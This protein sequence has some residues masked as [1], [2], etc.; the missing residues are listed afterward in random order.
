MPELLCPRCRQAV[1]AADAAF[2]PFC[3]EK[4]KK[5]GPDLAA[6]LQ[7][8][9]PVKKHDRL[10]ALREQ[11][12]DNLAIAEEILHLGRLYD[13][14]KKGVDFSIIK[15]Y[16]LNIYLE[17]ETLKK[18]KVEELRR[19][20]F[21]HPDLDA[22]LRLAGDKE[23]FLHRYL[24]RL[25]DEFIRLFLQGSSRY[26]H[27]IFG[28]VSTGKAPKYLAQPAA[29]MLLNM[30]LDEALDGEQR[31][32]LMRAFYAAFACRLDG[33]TKFLDEIL[34]KYDLGVETH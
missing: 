11:Y 5:D 10:L 1:A 30:K 33:E 7:E 4:L 28:F 32:R 9:D 24:M 31:A 6:V 12:P 14:G 27:Q 34:K 2:C 20:I 21:H 23:E 18:S 8:A 15:C 13:R 19:E 3:G 22:C 29:K 25:S 26:M 17:P 16:V